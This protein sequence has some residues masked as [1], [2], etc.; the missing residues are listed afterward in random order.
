MQCLSVLFRPGTTACRILHIQ[1]QLSRELQLTVGSALQSVLAWQVHL[2]VY[3]PQPPGGLE[4][5]SPGGLCSKPHS[6]TEVTESLAFLQFTVARE[7]RGS[8]C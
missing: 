8:T 3:G 7:V 6:Q 5:R 4:V 1:T 2:R